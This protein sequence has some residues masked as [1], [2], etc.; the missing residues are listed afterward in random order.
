LNGCPFRLEVVERTY[1][2]ITAIWLDQKHGTLWGGAV[3]RGMIVAL[4][5][6]SAGFQVIQ[7]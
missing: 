1:S 4:P 6:S 7:N 5:G 3:S 2:P